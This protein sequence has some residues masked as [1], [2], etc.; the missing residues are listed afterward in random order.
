MVDTTELENYLSDLSVSLDLRIKRLIT[1][2]NL[3]FY[4]KADLGEMLK[5]TITNEDEKRFKQQIGRLKDSIDYWRRR[6]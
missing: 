5:N 6:S 2:Q 4:I 3:N 1:T